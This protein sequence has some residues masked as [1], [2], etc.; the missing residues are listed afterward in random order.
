VLHVSVKNKT[1]IRFYE[2][3]GYER[4]ERA[5]VFY[6]DSGDAWM[7]RKALLVESDEA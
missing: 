1:A 4:L 2:R 6:G 3:V 5:A 7:Y